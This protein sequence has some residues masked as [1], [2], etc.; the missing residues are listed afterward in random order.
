MCVSWNTGSWIFH[1]MPVCR[2]CRRLVELGVVQ[3][4]NL[5]GARLDMN[6]AVV[7]QR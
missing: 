6:T 7:A 2:R 5:G 1:G 3:L 4:V